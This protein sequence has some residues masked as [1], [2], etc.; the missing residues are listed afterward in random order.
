MCFYNLIL[1]F[2]ALNEMLVEAWGLP[3][4]VDQNLHVK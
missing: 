1:R 2:E 3:D 4:L